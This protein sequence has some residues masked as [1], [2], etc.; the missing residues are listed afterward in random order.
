MLDFTMQF[1]QKGF[2]V[3]PIAR[4]NRD[5]RCD[6]K[7]HTELPSDAKSFVASDAKTPQ[8]RF[9]I[10]GKCHKSSCENSAMLA[11][12]AKSWCVFNIERCEMPAVRT[13]IAVWPV[14]FFSLTEAPLPDPTPTPPNTLKR[15]RNGPATDPKR[16]QTDPK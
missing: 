11:C 8:Q 15:T 16:T 7:M 2:D 10:T 3:A 12:D 1:L 9:E 4:C 13:L 5:V 6:L 14:I